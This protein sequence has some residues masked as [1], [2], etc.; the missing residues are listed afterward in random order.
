MYSLHTESL[1][2]PND[3]PVLFALGQAVQCLNYMS[4]KGL[5]CAAFTGVEDIMNL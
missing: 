3:A 2:L 1:N 4:R 5:G